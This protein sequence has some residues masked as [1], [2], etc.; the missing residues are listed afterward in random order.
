MGMNF[1]DWNKKDSS[2]ASLTSKNNVQEDNSLYRELTLKKD[3]LAK[4]LP[5]GYFIFI[6]GHRLVVF[7]EQGNEVNNNQESRVLRQDN[8]EM[9]NIVVVGKEVHV[10]ESAEDR[11]TKLLSDSFAQD[12]MAQLPQSVKKMFSES[13][14]VNV[15][16]DPNVQDYLDEQYRLKTILD[17]GLQLNGFNSF[18]LHDVESF[19]TVHLNISDDVLKPLLSTRTINANVQY[20]LIIMV[21]S[22]DTNKYQ[23]V[24]KTFTFSELTVLNDIQMKGSKNFRIYMALFSQEEKSFMAYQPYNDLNFVLFEPTLEIVDNVLT[25]K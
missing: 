19:E 21:E 23:V 1:F 25:I 16:D 15:E 17:K 20:T 18:Q 7:D 24:R 3:I 8:T 9:D 13:T 4:Y 22:L 10:V 5:V 11:V 12:S 6:D 2:N 14:I